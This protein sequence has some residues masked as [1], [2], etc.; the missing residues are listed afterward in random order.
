[1]SAATPL[2]PDQPDLSLIIPVYNLERDLAAWAAL[3]SPGFQGRP[4]TDQERAP[5]ARFREELEKLP[6]EPGRN[7]FRTTLARRLAEGRPGREL[8]A[9]GGLPLERLGLREA[10]SLALVPNRVLVRLGK[11]L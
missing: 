10:S 1:M 7:L 3:F 8:F 11:A 2:F 5:L 9:D 6:P 4:F